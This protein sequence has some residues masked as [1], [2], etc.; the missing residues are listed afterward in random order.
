[1][2]VMSSSCVI[3][4]IRRE[5]STWMQVRATLTRTV[6]DPAR[7]TVSQVTGDLFGVWGLRMQLGRGLRPGDDSPGAPAVVVLSERSWREA[8]GR[9]PSVI[10]ETVGVDGVP[11]EVRWCVDVRGWNGRF[12]QHRHVGARSGQADCRARFAARHGDWAIGRRR[13]RGQRA[14]GVARHR[15]GTR[16]RASGVESWAN[17][18]GRLGDLRWA[19]RT[20]TS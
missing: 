15:A 3:A 6:F 8:F 1:M 14:G 11:R 16:G 17:R 7:L 10:G 2:S 20:C 19:G 13:N 4:R 18:I 9:S 5:H 12:R